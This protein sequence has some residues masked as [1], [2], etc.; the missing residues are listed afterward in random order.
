M[1]L[2]FRSFDRVNDFSYHINKYKKSPRA[3]TSYDVFVPDTLGGTYEMIL[4]PGS[5][6]ITFFTKRDAPI[7]IT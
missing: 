1:A 7:F 3:V 4:T 6:I 2:N 5:T